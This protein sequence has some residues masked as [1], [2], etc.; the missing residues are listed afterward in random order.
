MS[1]FNVEN[2]SPTTGNYTFAAV[3]GI[4]NYS[5]LQTSLK[6]V[7]NDN[8]N[9]LENLRIEICVRSQELHIIIGENL[10]V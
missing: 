1:E 9:F 8:N 10:K 2:F 5:P 4:E 3:K 6:Y 7:W